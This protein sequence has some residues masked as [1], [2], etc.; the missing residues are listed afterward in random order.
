MCLKS[1]REINKQMKINKP[2][3]NNTNKKLKNKQMSK[4]QTKQTDRQTE[5]CEGDNSSKPLSLFF[6]SHGMLGLGPAL[7]CDLRSQ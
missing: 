2:S 3:R 7:K 6:V 4:N 5:H 1:V